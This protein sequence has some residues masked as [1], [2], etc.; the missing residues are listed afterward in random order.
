M[1]VIA[2]LPA[3]SGMATAH[4]GMGMAAAAGNTRLVGSGSAC[5]MSRATMRIAAVLVIS[6]VIVR[7]I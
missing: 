7:N 4:C 2:A 5:E 3:A 1:V 6:A